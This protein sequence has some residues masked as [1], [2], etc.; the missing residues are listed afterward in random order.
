MCRASKFANVQSEP[1]EQPIGSPGGGEERRPGT[2]PVAE[3]YDLLPSPGRDR[4][5]RG[6]ARGPARLPCPAGIACDGP[7]RRVPTRTSWPCSPATPHEMNLCSGFAGTPDLSF[8]PGV[9]Y[10]DVWAFGAVLFKMLT[11]NRAFRDEG[12]TDTIVSV[13]RNEPDKY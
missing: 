8:G 4:L 10:P 5:W 13:I 1:S 11:G 9:R 7:I 2:E 3:L 12:I 6:A